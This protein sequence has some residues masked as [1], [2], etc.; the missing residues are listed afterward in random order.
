MRFQ[1]SISTFWKRKRGVML[2][3]LVGANLTAMQIGD[4]FVK[5]INDKYGFLI[6]KLGKFGSISFYYSNYC[7]KNKIYVFFDQNENE[8]NVPSDMRDVETWLSKTLY[9]IKEK[10]TNASN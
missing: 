4:D 8:V 9:E 6:N 3:L 10:T 7:E 2:R 1:P 5:L